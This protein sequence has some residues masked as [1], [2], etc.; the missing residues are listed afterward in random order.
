MASDH[1]HLP[2]N[3]LFSKEVFKEI[4]PHIPRH[5][6]PDEVVRGSFTPAPTGYWLEGS[7]EGFPSAAAQQAQMY[8]QGAGVKLVMASP[9]GYAAVGVFRL[10]RWRDSALY[11]LLPVMFAIPLLN[12]LSDDLMRWNVVLFAVNVVVLMITHGLLVRGRIRL[13]ES[14]FTADIPA[15]GFRLRNAIQHSL[16]ED[17]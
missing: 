3:S 14:S 4:R 5:Y 15:P 13:S 7:F 1:I 12:A 16:G 17:A 10:Q 11:A 2:P 6:W 8:V 9:V